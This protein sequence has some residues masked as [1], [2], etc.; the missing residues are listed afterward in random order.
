MVKFKKFLA[1]IMSA[2]LIFS[3]TACSKDKDEDEK[4]KET[5]SS[6]SEEGED[7]DKEDGK[8]DEGDKKDDE[9]GSSAADIY[10]AL[11][12]ASEYDKGTYAWDMS[13]SADVDGE[14]V[15]MS[16]AMDGVIDGT[17]MTMGLVLEMENAG[18][19]LSLD[20]D[21][22]ITVVD[23]MAY[24]NLDAALKAMSGVDTE[25]G[26]YGLPLPEVEATDTT[27]MTGYME[28]ALKALFT[29]VEAE[30]DGDTFTVKLET[31]EE[32]VE[33]IKALVAYLD[34]NKDDINA[35]VKASADGIDYKAYLIE[36]VEYASEDIMGVCELMGSP[37]TQDEIDALIDSI[38]EGEITESD[39]DLFENFDEV[40]TQV[41]ELT[42]EDME[43]FLEEAD[44]VT[45]L[46]VTAGDDFSVEF[47]LIGEKD[48]A[49]VISV[50]MSYV[51]TSDDSVSVEAPENETTLTDA[52]QYFV[53]NPDVMQEVVDGV[54]A[55]AESFGG[56][57]SV[58]A[59]V[60]DNPVDDPDVD[61][62][63]EPSVSADGSQ[64]FVMSSGDEVTISWDSD[65]FTA[66]YVD[67]DWGELWLLTTDG[68]ET[69]V[70]IY[71]EE[72]SSA[73]D[74]YDG[75]IEFYEEYGEDDS[76]SIS[77]SGQ[78]TIGSKTV[79]YIHFNT[80][81]EGVYNSMYMVDLAED[82]CVEFDVYYFDD[83]TSTPEELISSI[84]IQF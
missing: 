24:I 51:I 75:W 61:D 62:P 59:P 64:T 37:I 56:G 72:Y 80:P 15:D 11:A 20:A 58:D 5:V 78:T 34:E 1:I 76:Y 10:E 63:D 36:L 69:E 25:M 84:E 35:A 21:D 41:E 57:N 42:V 17:N 47:S 31:A 12:K 28:G 23:G 48:D 4:D 53:D 46:S 81:Y 71:I 74:D 22:L 8:D 33:G 67:E 68:T 26:C 82:C 6:E 30:Q 79:Y 2:S 66:D 70:D 83:T 7:K 40:V 19:T 39:I 52:L 18:E 29:K 44:L 54:N 38:N 65:M 13:A 60:V 14:A 3:M 32:Y 16:L 77:E 27:E 50:E 43:E 55:W 45:E 49:D 73:Q 9:G